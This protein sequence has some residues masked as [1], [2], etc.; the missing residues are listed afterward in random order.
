M[1][2]RRA[3]TE[4]VTNDV[5]AFRGDQPDRKGAVEEQADVCFNESRSEPNRDVTR[6]MCNVQMCDHRNVFG[7]HRA[8]SCGSR[9]ETRGDRLDHASILLGNVEI[10]SGTPRS[11]G[12]GHIRRSRRTRLAGV[13]GRHHSSHDEWSRGQR[14][15][16]PIAEVLERWEHILFPIVLIGLGIVILVSGGAFGL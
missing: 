2:S 8:N 9:P 7:R 14:F 10:T 15:C 16:P 5:L 3:D 1:L 13:I 4:Q 6:K 12:V 11:D